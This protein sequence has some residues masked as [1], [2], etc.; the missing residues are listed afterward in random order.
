MI[1]SYE[2]LKEPAPIVLIGSSVLTL[3]MSL[4][5]MD[6]SSFNT[7][8]WLHRKNFSVD[9]LKLDT[10]GAPTSGNQAAFD[11]T[12]TGAMISD[13]YLMARKYALA[14]KKPKWLV[15]GVIPRD[16]MDT[17]PAKTLQFSC[18]PTIKDFSWVKPLY[19]TSFND[20]VDFLMSR[21]CFFHT[22]SWWM[23]GK[24]EDALRNLPIDYPQTTVRTIDQKDPAKRWAASIKEYRG[25]YS[26][27]P[28]KSVVADEFRF[29]EQLG[30]L[31]RTND[32]KLL[33]VNMPIPAENRDL[34]VKD[35]YKRYKN[36]LSTISRA[37]GAIYLDLEG[38]DNFIAE[39][40]F[41]SSHLNR[42]GATKLCRIIS[43][44][45][46]NSQAATAS[47]DAG[48]AKLNSN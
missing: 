13:S 12:F 8:T 27:R 32:V 40:Y 33:V 16:V 24:A 38:S 48:E 5:E 43:E 1:A 4:L 31:A 42:K 30:V 41:D 39:D 34:L 47:P 3:P 21:V 26:H 37:Q 2:G 15:L 25:L 18:L 19:L 36:T 9:A 14:G 10:P 28:R 6:E 45:M 29:L 23:K 44:T 46:M 20:R 22:Y 7:D 17:R 35:F 11:M